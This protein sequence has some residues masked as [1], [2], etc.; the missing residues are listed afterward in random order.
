MY[1]AIPTGLDDRSDFIY[2]RGRSMDNN[3]GLEGLSG[4]KKDL[5][6]VVT[7]VIFWDP[8]GAWLRLP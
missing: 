5:I 3:V 4:Q 7:S 2:N 8:F 1:G 6:R